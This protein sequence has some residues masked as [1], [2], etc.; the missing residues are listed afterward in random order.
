MRA[1]IEVICSY[2]LLNYFE[3][4]VARV[5]VVRPIFCVVY[6]ATNLTDNR[7]GDVSWKTSMQNCF[8]Q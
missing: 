6:K 3:L 4:T 2:V 8:A 7:T 1:L 5:L